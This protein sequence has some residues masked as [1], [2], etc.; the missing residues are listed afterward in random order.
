CLSSDGRYALVTHILANYELVP[1]QVVGGWTNTNVMS[2]V[3]TM[4]T[5]LI[6]TVLLDD[7]YRGA[8]NPWGVSCSAL[9]QW[10]CVAH[11]GTNDLSVIDGPALLEKLSRGAYRR[12]MVSGIPNSTSVLVGLRKR[13]PLEGKGTRA[14]AVV[15]TR[16]YVAGYFS[17]TLDVVDLATQASV[18]Q[19]TIALGPEP[20]WTVERRGEYLFN[21]ASICY[22][23]WQSCASCHP[24]ARAD[25]LN[26]DLVNDGVGNPK[27]TKS[28]LLAHRTPP[29]MITGVRAS[30]EVAVRSGLEHILFADQP[31]EVAAAIDAYL[32]S[33][34]AVASPYLETG[35]LS[36]VARRGRQLFENESVGCSKCHPAPWYTDRAT[37][38]V[39]TQ[40]PYDHRSTFD[41]P[42]LIETWRTA[43]Y[44]HDGRYVTVWELLRKGRHGRSHGHVDQLTDRQIEDLAQFVL[45]L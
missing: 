45:S 9:G 2:V 3:D 27:N 19:K 41:T 13:V 39:L 44:L 1:A 4:E 6:N 12:A 7:P 23:Q 29:A 18:P 32:R 38:N 30:A 14:L 21:D 11:A 35:R 37:H 16:A 40:G 25:G 15:G 43:P 33:L 24:D 17:D 8:A 31:E 36:P 10:I 20:R 42:A 5:K 28:M 34:V 26:W 22:Q